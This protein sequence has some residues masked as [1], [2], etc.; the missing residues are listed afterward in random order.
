MKTL[1]KDT[2]WLIHF[3]IF[4]F[5]SAASVNV[6]IARNVKVLEINFSKIKYMEYIFLFN[7]LVTF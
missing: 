3:N 5:L 2:S 7:K 6:V 1:A 4:Q